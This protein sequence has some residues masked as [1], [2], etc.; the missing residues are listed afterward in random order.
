MKSRWTI[1]AAVVAGLLLVCLTLNRGILSEGDSSK[2]AAP[3]KQSPRPGSSAARTGREGATR[4]KPLETERER[5]QRI[6]SNDA[7]RSDFKLSEQDIYLFL[8]TK[9]SNALS[10]VA[11]FESTRDKEYLKNAIAMYPHDPFVQAKALMWLDLSDDERAKLTE[12]L[13]KT[14]PTNAFANFLAAR[15]AMKRGDTQSALAE[16]AGAKGKGFDEYFRESSE[17]LEAAYASAGFSD[18]EARILGSSEITL[19]YL[20]QFKS[21][22]RQFIELAEKAATSGDAKTQQE[23]LMVNWEIGQKLRAPTGSAPIIT[24]LVGI[25]MEN[26]TLHAWPKDTPFGGHPAPEVINANNSEG[27]SLKIAGPALMEWLPAAPD[28]EIITFM[29]L[30]KNSGERRALAW[31]TDLHPE[32]RK[33]GSAH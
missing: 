24:E 11:G 26:A 1:A 4:S 9:G 7:D 6:I 31:L 10:L 32:L 16:L 22:G 2:S 19:P 20:A 29:D 23:L 30:Q 17:G 14:A 28:E 21:L 13:K 8:Q 5:R 25:A 18:A 27:K 15:D 33:A 12:D 3:T